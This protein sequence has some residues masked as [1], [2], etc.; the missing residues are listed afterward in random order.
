MNKKNIIPLIIVFLLGAF[1]M[2]ILIK[3]ENRKE[4]FEKTSLNNAINKVYDATVL[5]EAYN[6]SAIKNIGSGFFYK[7]DNKYAYIITNAHV[8]SNGVDIEIVNSKDQKV[9][10]ELLGKDTYLDIAVLRIDKK[11]SNKIVTI[12]S[13]KT[14]KLGDSIFTIGS[15]INS[16][17]KGTVTSGIISGKDRLV[18]V[19]NEEDEWIMKVI[20]LDASINP[21]NSGGPLVNV[22]GEVIGIVSL[23]LERE[24]IK[25]IGFAIPIEY[26]INNIEYL[27]NNKKIKYPELGIKIAESIDTA[28]LLRNNID[29]NQ[30]NDG[31]VVLENKNNLKKGD[32]IIKVNNNKVK[33]LLTLNCELRQYKIKDKVELTIIRNN[34]KRNIKISLS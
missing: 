28:T 16:S 8:V 13:N 24:D 27:E 18:K 26:A 2:F 5:I 15:P 30:E 1:S 34:I 10:A 19:D 4:V 11:Y 6:G 32:V 12:G 31:I 9:K 23:K 22:N 21:G 17:Y 25:G 14:T 33:D 7:K 29:I 20:Q 3:P